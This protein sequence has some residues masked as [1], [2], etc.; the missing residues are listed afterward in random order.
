MTFFARAATFAALTLGIAA[1]GIAVPGYAADRASDAV[2]VPAALPFSLILPATGATLEVTTSDAVVT[3]PADADQTELDAGYPDDATAARF[4]SLAD[5]VANQDRPGDLSAE[6]RCLAGAVYYEAKGE[7][8]AGQLAVAEVILNRARSGRFPSS[9]CGVVTQSGQFSFVR[10]GVVPAIDPAL[11]AYRLAVAV[12][13]VALED[14]W[15]SPASGAMFF[16]ARYAAPVWGK[17]R[18]A[19]IGN[20]VFYR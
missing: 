17:A 12:A 16:H 3:T 9:S 10:G 11:P 4:Q 19:S 6:L 5:A 18:V 14:A 20:H 13:Q 8:L 7:P 1:I 15:D 2:V